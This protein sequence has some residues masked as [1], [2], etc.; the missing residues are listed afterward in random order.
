MATSRAFFPRRVRA[1][2]GWPRP[3]DRRC[4]LGLLPFRALSPSFRA[5][6][7]SH[8]AGPHVLGWGDV[9]TYLD[10][11]A[12]RTGWIGLSRLRAAGSPGVLHLLVRSGTPFTTRRAGSWF[13][14]AQ[15]IA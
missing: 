7:C 8:E 14:L 12:S 13:H 2:V 3:P 4:L 10:L 9:P 6:A 1:V 5:L 15:D 11:R